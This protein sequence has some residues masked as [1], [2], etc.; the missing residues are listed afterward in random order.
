MPTRRDGPVTASVRSEV[1][2]QKPDVQSSPEARL[3]LSLA[4]HVDSAATPRDA[5]T[6][7]RELRAALSAFR[8]VIKAAGKRGDGVDDLRARRAARRKAG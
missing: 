2:A 7:S 5:A 1:D 8:E 6:V 4:M 3:C